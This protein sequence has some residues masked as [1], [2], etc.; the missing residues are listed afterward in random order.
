MDANK[1]LRNQAERHYG[2]MERLRE[3]M[4]QEQRDVERRIEE[5]NSRNNKD[6]DYY[7]A[8]ADSK[9]KELKKATEEIEKIK[10]KIKIE[11]EKLYEKQ[12]A[13]D[14]KAKAQLKKAKLLAQLN[15]ASDNDTELSD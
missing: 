1:I 6:L 7:M 11:A 14:K 3:S 9:A 10:T 12:R 13:K 5:C 15:E 4:T 8:Q 2:D